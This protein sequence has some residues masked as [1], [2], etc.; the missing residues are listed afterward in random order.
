MKFQTLNNRRRSLCLVSFSYVFF[1]FFNLKIPK[2][3]KFE[4]FCYALAPPA[5]DFCEVFWLTFISL[6]RLNSSWNGSS[7]LFCVCSSNTFTNCTFICSSVLIRCWLILESRDLTDPVPG[8]RLR[9]FKPNCVWNTML[10]AGVADVTS[11]SPAYVRLS[12]GCRGGE[13]AV[14]SSW[15]NI[16]TGPCRSFSSSSLSV[17]HPSGL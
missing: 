13:V 5:G 9:W 3:A 15:T 2:F 10:R 14:Q 16:A 11:R 4:L 8:P 1:L 12:V 6:T 7:D 17:S